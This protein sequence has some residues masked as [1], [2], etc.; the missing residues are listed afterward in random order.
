[1]KY[2][3]YIGLAAALVAYLFWGYMPK[4]YFYYGNAIF[5]FCIGL[6]L[7]LKDK[8]SFIKF[9]ILGLSINNLMDELFFDPKVIGI[10]EIFI[11]IILPII[12]IARFKKNDRTI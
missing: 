1:M 8:S 6:Y 12:Y 11:I 3:L 10:S 4:G 2:L 9:I 5:I 7:W